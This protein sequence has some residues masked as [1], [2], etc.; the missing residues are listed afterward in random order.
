MN[1]HSRI[2][3]FFM[4]MVLIVSTFIPSR[5]VS[6][7]PDTVNASYV[8]V[9]PTNIG[10]F[11]A[12]IWQVVN[13]ST[14]IGVDVAGC[15]LHILMKNTAVSDY[16]IGVR[17]RGSS[18]NRRISMGRNS[19]VG[20]S[21]NML[22]MFVTASDASGKEG[23]IEVY[24]ENIGHVPRIIGYFTGEVSYTEAWSVIVPDAYDAWTDYELF[25]NEGVPYGRVADMMI[26]TNH[27]VIYSSM[28][29]RTDGSALDRRILFTTSLNVAGFWGYSTYV[30]CSGS[31]GMI[32]YYAD[33]SSV[34]FYY[35]GYFDEN[36]HVVERWQ[37]ESYDSSASWVE[38][39]LTAYGIST[40]ATAI[41]IHRHD[42]YWND[43]TYGCSPPNL[44]ET[45]ELLSTR[46]DTMCRINT[47]NDGYSAMTWLCDVGSNDALWTYGENTGDGRWI[48]AGYLEFYT[49]PSFEISD[50][51]GCGNWVFA[52]E[53]YYSFEVTYSDF[54]GWD[55]LD[56][57]KIGFSDGANQVN[58]SY[59]VVDEEMTLDD[60]DDVVDL[61][62]G[63]IVSVSD[64]GLSV[65]YE[66]FFEGTILDALD[67]D[68]W[69]W[70][71]DTDGNEQTLVSVD[72]FNI[73]NL[74]GQET[75]VTSGDAGRIAGG[76]AFELYAYNN[77]WAMSNVT[78]RRLQG[79]H[80]LFYV[81]APKT[82]MDTDEGY[83]DRHRFYFGIDFCPYG[84]EWI[85]G[86]YVRVYNNE[87]WV[88]ATKI[89]VTWAIDWFY[90]GVQIGDTELMESFFEWD[91][92]TTD[93]FA[94][95][96][97]DLWFNKVNASSMVG[98]RINSEYYGM[99]DTAN[100]WLRWW[101]TNWGP[102]STNVTQ[103]MMFTPLTNTAGDTISIK[104]LKMMRVWSRIES[105][106]NTGNNYTWTLTDYDLQDFK[107][108][109]P[110]EKMQGIDTPT[111]IDTKVVH[112]PNT[113]FYASLVA[114]VQNQ[115]NMIATAISYGGLQL[116]S[117]FVGFLDSVAAIF[118]YPKLFTNLFAW[119]ASTW[120]WMVTSFTNG[121]LFL[122]QIFLFVAVS[123]T[124]LLAIFTVF[125]TNFIT[126][127]STFVDYITGGYGTGLNMI[128]ALGI[129]SWLQLFAIFYPLWLIFLWDQ[130]GIDALVAHLT[131]V[132]NILTFG[133]HLFLGVAEFGLG[134]IFRVIEAIP[135]A[136]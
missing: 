56:V 6:G 98:G 117:V 31:T 65:T 74:G 124:D 52:E 97:V 22:T 102:T 113:G 18:L 17:E 118:G 21:G 95:L 12:G 130:Q 34:Y 3:F 79:Y 122:T 11:G 125:V 51:E 115:M 25:T 33:H 135:V 133:L 40:N 70:S 37:V 71:N 61:Q 27:T 15:V 26:V 134:L 119:I 53:R 103:S 91:S 76:D 100:T 39:D 94:G 106:V 36:I 107:T 77:S 120:G 8:E 29:I 127:W 24:N 67:V 48:Y 35:G 99:T 123:F 121:I 44:T 81:K 2:L 60:G 86:W 38:Q 32:E 63:T 111:L 85:Q 13:V 41:I 20:S 9:V 88:G 57:C 75:L 89:H 14:I 93:G 92:T 23:T 116:F 131:F 59:S 19:G 49:P 72:Y 64:E 126:I 112:M 80:T 96:Y 47:Q 42:T 66:L 104:Q 82:M 83:T 105:G 1:R 69:T 5:P 73:Y 55:T 54:D 132:M 4:V 129:M 108:V 45:G 68:V 101:N 28:G 87:T 78:Y 114:A 16:D 46:Y 7:F 62:I 10:T 128:E 43:R 30:T 136:E 90:R 109:S 50:M 84:E 110:R 58:A